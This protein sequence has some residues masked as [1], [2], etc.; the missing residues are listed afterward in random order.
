MDL[1]DSTYMINGCNNYLI[2]YL[3]LYH[4]FYM[5]YLMKCTHQMIIYNGVKL[6]TINWSLNQR[7]I[8]N[9][10]I[11]HYLHLKSFG[12]GYSLV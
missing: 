4:K 10:E 1:V 7:P 2:Q 6:P 3:H 9:I 5:H 8:F 11:I 12:F